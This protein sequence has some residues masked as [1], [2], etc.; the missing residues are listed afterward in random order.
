MGGRFINTEPSPDNIRAIWD[1]IHGLNDSLTTAND[2]ITKQAATIT[3]LQSDLSTTAKHAQYAL[4]TASQSSTITGS[5]TGGGPAQPP[6]TDNGQGALGCS[7]A[8][9]NGHVTD[10]ASLT[11]LGK[12]VCGTGLEFPALLAAVANQGIRD[13]NRFELIGRMI[14]HINLNGGFQGA[15]RYPG[16]LFDI[17]VCLEG[18]QYAYRVTGYQTFETP[19]TTE[20]VFGGLTFGATCI[21]DPGISD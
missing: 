12:I 13:A 2:T 19:M 18:V 7:Q 4:M 16:N 14:W 6:V 20:M 21:S 5:G 17:L 3:T 15:S 11:V 10:P 9:V 8:A 1:A